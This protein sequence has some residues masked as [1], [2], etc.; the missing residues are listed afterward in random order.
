MA[1]RIA[2]TTTMLLA[3][4]S[5]LLEKAGYREVSSER[6]ESWP[7]PGAR[8]YEDPYSIAALV[9][10]E[11]WHDLST[12]WSDAQAA[13]AALMSR[14][15]TRDDSKSWDGYLVLLTPSV[16]P[17]EE[18]LVAAD[19]R[20][21]TRHV[22]KLVTTGDELRDLRDVLRTLLPLLPLEPNIVTPSQESV[23]DLLPDLLAG[24]GIEQEAVH[25]LIGAFAKQE[26]LVET[27]H[28]FFRG[29]EG[30]EATQS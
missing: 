24:H 8:V 1:E 11:T 10:Y 28:N 6:I 7:R 22:R 27:L 16:P 18:R 14:Y 17:E 9:A 4:A 20:S 12:G 30:D 29:N 3:A 26:P 15:L 13:L 5:E 2:F 23:L 19:I 25:V 21:N